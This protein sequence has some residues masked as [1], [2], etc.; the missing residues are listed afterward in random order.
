VSKLID[1]LRRVFRTNPT[2]IGFRSGTSPHPT[3]ALL[4]GYLSNTNREIIDSIGK[5]NLD[6]II[7]EGGAKGISSQDLSKLSKSFGSIPWGIFCTSDR[8]ENGDSFVKAGADFIVADTTSTPA[9]ALLQKQ[10]GHILAIEPDIPDSMAR[11]I[12][13]LGVEAVYLP[14]GLNDCPVLN[15]GNLLVCQRISGLLRK[16]LLASVSHELTS[17]D[18]QSLISAGIK[19]MVIKLADSNILVRIPEIK[20][21]LGT[22]SAPKTGGGE[23]TIPRINSE[24]PHPEEDEEPD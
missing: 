20:N 17:T 15:I 18:L 1:N 10:L 13:S 4:I 14:N 6:G 21:I 23:V 7:V 9:A 11:A 2:P 8:Y 12:D 16:P 24:K 3:P 5:S 22:L 19:G